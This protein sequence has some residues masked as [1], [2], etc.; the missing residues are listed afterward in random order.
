MSTMLLWSI[1][2]GFCLLLVVVVY[3]RFTDSVASKMAREQKSLDRKAGVEPNTVEKEKKGDDQGKKEFWLKVKVVGA[4]GIVAF[5]WSIYGAPG[6]RP[7][8]MGNWGKE[9]W[10]Q[11]LIVWV[12]LGVLLA[13]SEMPKMFQW[14]LAGTALG[15][16][17]VL[18]IWSAVSSPKK[19]SAPTKHLEIPLA[20]GPES[21]WPEPSWPHLA[22]WK[23]GE[24]SEL[25]PSLPKKQL[26][27]WGR[28]IRLDCVYRD[29]HEV[30]FL[31]GEKRCPDGDMA[32]YYVT[33]LAKEPN[34]VRLAYG[35]PVI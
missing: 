6:V 10:L 21:S 35:D 28:D 11:I 24:K 13:L 9:Y 26:L 8:G 5:L 19:A 14:V 15:L 1:L 2:V 32:G 34:T 3:F 16:L 4:I 18:P 30:S 17:I 27:V 29:G 33:N 22:L 20:R 23:E 31:K 12:T 25:I 7:A